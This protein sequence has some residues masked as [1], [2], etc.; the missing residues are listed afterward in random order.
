M[1]EMAVCYVF[2]PGRH[3]STDM[4]S[5]WYLH[6][7]LKVPWFELYLL[8]CQDS[9]WSKLFDA[10]GNPE[11][12]FL[13]IFEKK[14]AGH[15]N[16]WKISQRAKSYL[17]TPSPNHLVL[18]CILLASVSLHSIKTKINFFQRSVFW[19]WENLY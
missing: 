14:F 10:D 8:L 5:T 6:L 16:L 3:R 13:C 17:P 7:L 4:C 1:A 11:R 12:N 18:V 9:S 19:F 2:K 15:N